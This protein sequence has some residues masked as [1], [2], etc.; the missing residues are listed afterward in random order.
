M[1]AEERAELVKDRTAEI[2]ERTALALASVPNPD[3]EITNEEGAPQGGSVD[4]AK[5]GSSA[6][7]AALETIKSEVCVHTHSDGHKAKVAAMK[8][9]TSAKK[10]KRKKGTKPSKSETDL[11]ASDQAR[12]ERDDF[13]QII[14]SDSDPPDAPSFTPDAAMA[15][16]DLG[17]FG[18]EVSE[19][20]PSS[21]ES[22]VANSTATSGYTTEE[23]GEYEEDEE[24]EQEEGDWC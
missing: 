1:K 10:K 15:V 9:Q 21:E 16:A 14:T 17:G 18:I 13:D 8:A 19:A 12:D 2:M 3:G 23:G 7:K 4:I 20:P 22:S 24:G 11:L 6:T 5:R